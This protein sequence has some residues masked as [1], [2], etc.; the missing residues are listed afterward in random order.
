MGMQSSPLAHKK[1][2]IYAFDYL[3]G[4]FIAVII[5]DHVWKFPSLW[6]AFTGE[7]RLWVTAA[8]GFIMISGFLIGYI[9]GL[10]GMKL[11]FSVIASTLL[12]RAFMLYVWMILVSIAY[13]AIDWYLT[14]VPDIPSLPAAV[15]DWSE[16]IRLIVTM[17]H[18]NLWIHFLS[19]YTIFLAL[20]VPVVWLL[21]NNK[22][23]LVGVLTLVIYLLGA[24]YDVEWMKWQ[25]PFFVMALFGFYFESLRVW[26]SSIGKQRRLQTQIAIYAAALLTLA[27]SVVCVYFPA[28]LPSAL[29]ESLN[30][31]FNIELFS[32]A[33]VVL[34]VIWFGALAF[35][36]HH[37]TPF[38]RRWS[39]GVLEFL[40]THSLSA[41]IIH[42]FVICA[43]N[44]FLVVS[45]LSQGFILNTLIG[46]GTVL[47]VY[48]LLR[49]P[50]VAKIIPR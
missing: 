22:S 39:Y 50:F 26:W 8:E 42:G 36:F 2:R 37:F 27:L 12:R 32:I 48:G 28:T 11:P 23:W 17:E 15:G 13:T 10:K 33:R 38:I 47:A 9:R 25:L 30:R 5:I 40:G 49:I 31:L 18:P 21:R 24:V 4:Y 45:G 19:L 16:A 6:T 44:Y 20:S 35:L 34:A 29:V 3:R 41:Y 43:V 46:L 1:E 14:A 7:A